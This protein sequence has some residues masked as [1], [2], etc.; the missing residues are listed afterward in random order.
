[1]CC[2]SAGFIS[3]LVTLGLRFLGGV[4]N[5]SKVFSREP[6]SLSTT[7][8]TSSPISNRSIDSSSTPLPN[9]RPL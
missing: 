6:P 3:I 5:R 8:G 9:Q 7:R 4:R 2:I 1:M